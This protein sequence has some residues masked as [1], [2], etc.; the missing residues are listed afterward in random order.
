[1]SLKKYKSGNALGSVIYLYL[2]SIPLK[3]TKTV[4]KRWIDRLKTCMRVEGE[5]FERQN[6]L[7]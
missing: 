1:M 3:G 5:Y 6:K 7:K 2:M 4:L